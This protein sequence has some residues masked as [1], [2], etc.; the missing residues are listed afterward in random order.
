MKTPAS[1]DNDSKI[2]ASQDHLHAPPIDFYSSL[3]LPEVLNRYRNGTQ[4]FPSHVLD[5]DDE[6]LDAEHDGIQGVG[7]W[8]LRHLLGH[9]MDAEMMNT[10]RMRKAYAE[11][12]AI[13]PDWDEHAYIDAGIYGPSKASANRAGQPVAAFIAMIHTTRQVTANWLGRLREDDWERSGLH[14]R[15]GE[16]SLRT[17][18]DH[19]TWHLDH[20]AVFLRRKL[21]RLGVQCPEPAAE[22][23]GPGCGCHGGN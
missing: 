19:T 7:L 14:P 9:L 12:G 3:S 21:D 5:L 15:R 16:M 1:T 8:S 17:V 23:C 2:D 13:F 10:L 18:L 20:H 22:A 6:V 11:D 4:Q